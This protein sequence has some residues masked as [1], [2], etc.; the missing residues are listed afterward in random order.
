MKPD[1]TNCR[2]VKYKI[3]NC[4]CCSL[5][6]SKKTLKAPRETLLFGQ[7]CSKEPVSESSAQQANRFPLSGPRDLISAFTKE[8]DCN[9]SCAAREKDA[10]LAVSLQNSSVFKNSGAL[11]QMQTKNSSSDSASGDP[12]SAQ[13]DDQRQ[14]TSD[15]TL[16]GILTEFMGNCCTYSEERNEALHQ[17]RSIFL[18][19]EE[20]GA[21]DGYVQI[22]FCVHESN[23]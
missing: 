13:P 20:L 4:D 8:R 21:K 19:N 12:H 22:C 10:A 5:L 9:E 3:S 14:L 18:V 7:V 15:V 16:N 6:D 23:T 1:C 2:S 11:P 17:N